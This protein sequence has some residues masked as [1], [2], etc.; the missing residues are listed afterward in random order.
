MKTGKTVHRWYYY[1]IDTDGKQIQRSC[2][3]CRNRSEA[4]NYIRSIPPPPGAAGI[5]PTPDVRIRD[6]TRDMYIPGSDHIRRRKQ[7]G[8]STNPDTMTEGR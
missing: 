6:I 8:K 4:E 7:L 5:Q 2:R 3:G 1:W